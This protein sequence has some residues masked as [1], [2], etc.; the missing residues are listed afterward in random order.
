MRG[1]VRGITPLWSSMRERAYNFSAH[2][3]VG[4]ALAP[5]CTNDCLYATRRKQKLKIR[6]IPSVKFHACG[7]IPRA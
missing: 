4:R 2:F 3:R 1:A 7:P 5:Y 6:A